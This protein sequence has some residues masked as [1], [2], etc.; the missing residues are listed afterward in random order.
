MKRKKVCIIS[1][2]LGK[3]GLERSCA[4]LSILLSESA[5]DVHL[6]T[7]CD[8][9]D[10]EYKGELFNLGKFK[11]K[12]DTLLKRLRRFRKLRKYFK[13]H[14]FDYIIDSRIGNNS[15]R[16]L[17]Y[18]LY[19][20]GRKSKVIYMQHSSNLKNHF[21]DKSFLADLLVKYAYVFV[22]VS[23]G[24]SAKFNQKYGTIKCRT[25][26]NHKRELEPLA[27]AC[28]YPQAYILFLGRLVDE[29][30]NLSLLL[31]AYQLSSLSVQG[32]KLLIMGAGADKA[33][34]QNKIKALNL[35]ESIVLKS[36]SPNIYS[37][38][39]QARFLVLT[40][41]YE[42]FPMVLVEALSCG[43][44]V[45]SVDC[46]SGPCE[47]IQQEK[48]G[49]LVENFNVEVLSQ[50]MKRMVYDKELYQRCKNNAARSVDFLAKDRIAEQWR[51]VLA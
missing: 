45:V 24:I 40:S 48:N 38:L 32:I 14:R 17:C 34:L 35:T 12:N 39:S 15:R 31:D 30:K 13:K 47:I 29:V 26:Y 43:T 3:G 5:Y 9:V 1:V 20:Y 25:V 36:F 4:N 6:V 10:Y 46:K 18:M 16:E 41:R 23:Q 7:L 33:F 37:V 42:G 21:P 44:P 8:D 49:L 22:G 19:I 11:T 50:A 27:D 28:I 51:E 2:S